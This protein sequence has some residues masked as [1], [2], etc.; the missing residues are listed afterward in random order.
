MPA[1]CKIFT[2]VSSASSSSSLLYD[3]SKADADN[4]AG[5][6]SM[7]IPDSNAKTMLTEIVF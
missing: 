5:T 7:P 3:N 4:L 6:P 1:R 2:P